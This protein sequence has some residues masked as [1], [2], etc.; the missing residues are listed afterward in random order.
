M[1]ASPATSI[2]SA[3]WVAQALQAAES[4]GPAWSLPALERIR[5]PDARTAGLSLSGAIVLL[6]AV[7]DW[8]TKPDFSPAFLYLFPVML[9]ALF[10]PRFAVAFLGCL[11]AAV[12][13]LLRAPAPSPLR[14]S[15]EALALIGCGLFVAELVRNRRLTLDAEAGLRVLVETSP[16]AILTVDGDGFI[17]LANQAA[18]DLIVPR[19][20][21]LKGMPIAAFLPELYYA[22]TGDGAGRRREPLK[23]ACRRGNG[24]S[25][26][27]VVRF[28]IYREGRA[29]KLS[30]IVV[31]GSASRQPIETEEAP[32]CRVPEAWSERE[33]KVFRCLLKG[34]ANKEIAAFLGISESGVKNTLQQLFA[35]TGVRTRSQLVRVALGQDRRDSSPDVSAP[36][37]ESGR[38]MAFDR[39]RAP[40]NR[41]GSEWTVS[42][43]PGGIGALEGPDELRAAGPSCRLSPAARRALSTRRREIPFEWSTQAA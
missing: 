40:A 10:L 6:I 17:E 18:V 14:L 23:C 9:S 31:D 26:D 38:V 41:G 8:W 5:K 7:A 11:C 24:E 28:S 19:E 16:A 32:A 25:F 12:A 30:A 21:V 20:G 43:L 42:Q 37:E 3:G 22:L 36:V 35:R 4:K 15:F 27:A 29:R 34:M 2:Y 1:T 39:W 13:E 33:S